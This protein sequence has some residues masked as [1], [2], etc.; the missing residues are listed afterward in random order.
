MKRDDL[1]RLAGA[2]EPGKE[3]KM[4]VIKAASKPHGFR[5]EKPGRIVSALGAAAVLFACV[6]GGAFLLKDWM[7]SGTANGS[8]MA[9]SQ[10][11]APASQA[12]A[13]ATQPGTAAPGMTAGSAVTDGVIPP[14]QAVTLA[15]AA[16]LNYFSIDTGNCDV[17]DEFTKEGA[18][19]LLGSD[20]LVDSGAYANKAFL[21][22]SILGNCW[23]FQYCANGVSSIDVQMSIDQATG[24]AV[25]GSLTGMAPEKAGYSKTE[26]DK[27]ADIAKQYVI[28]KGFP[29]DATIVKAANLE[30]DS[31]V[32][33]TLSDGRVI[34]LTLDKD[35]I[36]VGFRVTGR[37]T[38]VKETT[39]PGDVIS[40]E[41]AVTLARQAFKDLLGITVVDCPII[42]LTSGDQP[43]LLGS[44]EAVDP[45]IYADKVHLEIQFAEYSDISA[46]GLGKSGQKS[47]WTIQYFALATHTH[48]SMDAYISL[49]AST[50][51]AF[52]GDSTCGK[53]A[54]DTH[55][56]DAELNQQ[57]DIAR[58]FVQ[59]LPVTQGVDALNVEIVE[60][61]LNAGTA[62]P[63][64]YCVNLADGR[65]AHVV[66][67][68]DGKVLFF[69]LYNSGW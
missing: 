24:E 62:E 54:I 20:Q 15:R 39:I 55:L 56:T 65:C 43:R 48:I 9:A 12:S 21:E 13:A 3:L 6:V 34:T 38:A 16:Y 67:D 61:L 57:K 33:V 35:R 28:D 41:Q 42:D 26:L 19:R 63:M 37:K 59:K 47:E 49:D 32:A 25:F 8:G 14:E 44:G 5:L 11:S 4:R 30:M 45:D 66:L 17:I 40:P 22:M 27:R 58:V 36:V 64:R 7:K 29:G 51:F 60:D 18:A 46:T 10:P 1:I 23:Y 69:M 53:K 31:D 52:A 68:K 2:I 50:G